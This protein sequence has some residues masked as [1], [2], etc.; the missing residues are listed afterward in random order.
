MIQFCFLVL[1][2]YPKHLKLLSY[3]GTRC[4]HCTE[5]GPEDQS[6]GPCQEFDLGK[7]QILL[8]FP[9]VLKILPLAN[10]IS[11]AAGAH[12]LGPLGLIKPIMGDSPIE[13]HVF[14]ISL[15][16]GASRP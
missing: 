13:A 4:V 2:S 11:R 10:S 1:E 16:N 5:P 9:V 12:F 14:T 7:P 15:T 6:N 3:I 8:L